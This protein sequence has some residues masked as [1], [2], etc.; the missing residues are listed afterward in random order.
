[1]VRARLYVLYKKCA[2]I[3]LRRLKTS[4]HSAS[5]LL[6]RAAERLSAECWM[7]RTSCA[8]QIPVDI[9]LPLQSTGTR[10]KLPLSH[11]EP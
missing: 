3:M 11:I 2:E 6:L 7:N 10:L 9:R 1:M 5:H 4:H 8:H